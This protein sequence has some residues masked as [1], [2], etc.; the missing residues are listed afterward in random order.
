[1]IIFHWNCFNKQFGEKLSNCESFHR[2][3]SDQMAK[4]TPFFGRVN[5]NFLKFSRFLIKFTCTLVAALS[6]GE[7]ICWATISVKPV[8]SPRNL[9]NTKRSKGLTFNRLS[10]LVNLMPNSSQSMGKLVSTSPTTWANK[11][12][13][14]RKKNIVKSSGACFT[15]CYFWVF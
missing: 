12:K 10:S 3:F 11:K 15:H 2:T 7:G 9:W 8:K 14:I 4:C 1:M 13:K 6:R 5:S